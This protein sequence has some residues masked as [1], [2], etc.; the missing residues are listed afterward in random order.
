MRSGAASCDSHRPAANPE[1]H[2]KAGKQTRIN[3][4]FEYLAVGKGAGLVV[5]K[6][7]FQHF[8]I[9]ASSFDCLLAV[10]AEGWRSAGFLGSL[11]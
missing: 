8:S 10:L 7:Y 3:S 1:T 6:R 11:T 5:G 4:V 2:V 9:Q